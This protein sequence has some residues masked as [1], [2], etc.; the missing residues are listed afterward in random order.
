MQ[1][2]EIK[3]RDQKPTI[4]IQVS[5]PPSY[6]DV[7]PDLDLSNDPDAPRHPLLD[8][9]TDKA[10][11]LEALDPMIEE[12]LGMAMVFTLVTTLKD[13]AETLISERQNQAQ[14]AVEAASRKAEAE[15]NKRF[16]GTQVNRQSFLE[17]RTKFRA[18]MQEREKLA[19]EEAEAEDKKKGV[20]TRP[21]EKKLTGRQLWEKGLAGKVDDAELEADGD[22]ALA[23]IDH[24][25]LGTNP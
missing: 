14:Q 10:E 11:L 24:L 2:A 15:E 8:V 19:K 7:G 25:K 23:G 22:D 3:M 16:E 17:W 6:P 9:A 20:R 21:E 18:E 12:S 13:K 1:M 5:Y 4:L